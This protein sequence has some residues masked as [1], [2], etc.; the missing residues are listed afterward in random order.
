VIMSNPIPAPVQ[1]FQLASVINHV[2]NNNVAYL[3]GVLIAHMLGL[4]EKV[5]GYG[6]GMC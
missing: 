1:A 4:L 2:R 6:S 3:L 5:W